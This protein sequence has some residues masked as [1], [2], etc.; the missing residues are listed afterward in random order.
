[1]KP[2]SL[3]LL[4]IAVVLCCCKRSKNV[5][6]ADRAAVSKDINT[7]LAALSDSVRKSGLIGW[8]PFLDSSSEFQWVFMGSALSYDSLLEGFRRVDSSFSSFAI[9]WDSVH[10]ECLAENEATLFA[11]YNET[12]VDSSGA[13]A[14]TAFDISAN[15]RRING[16]WKFHNCQMS[17]HAEPHPGPNIAEADTSR[18]LAQTIDGL[19]KAMLGPS[20]GASNILDVDDRTANASYRVYQSMGYIFED[21]GHQLE[22]SYIVTIHGQNDSASIAIVRNNRIVWCSRPLLPSMGF[23]PLPG[24]G[25]LN[26]DGTT[27]ILFNTPLDMRGYGEALW[28]ISPDS[29]DGRLLNAVDQEGQS[30]IVGGTRTFEFVQPNP[31]GPKLIK[32]D[33]FSGDLNSKFMYTWNGSVFVKADSTDAR[34]GR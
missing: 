22:H 24:F 21:P 13:Q 31:K 4:C 15:L 29:S 14:A 25:D 2:I 20:Y 6:Q 11:I 30:V 7:M 32:A 9:S 19:V 5:S 17:E 3:F 34:T 27:D 33:D 23:A 28:I 8:A 16:S 10:V 12:G 26:N 1:M 18:E